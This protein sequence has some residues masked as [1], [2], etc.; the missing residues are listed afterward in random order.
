M[1]THE[2][3]H[4][5]SWRVDNI[6]KARQARGQEVDPRHTE[7]GVDFCRRLA[8]AARANGY[9]VGDLPDALNWPTRTTIPRRMRE[10]R[11]TIVELIAIL[12]KVPV[13]VDAIIAAVN[14]DARTSQQAP[15]HIERDLDTTAGV[16]RPRRAAPPAPS[17]TAATASHGGAGQYLSE[18]DLNDPFVKQFAHLLPDAPAPQE[19]NSL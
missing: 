18:E 1:S 10:G 16:D 8:D 12:D 4:E 17:A 5:H 14:E 11:I 7:R 19:G 13:S 2:H 3:E 15:V 6:A 9:S